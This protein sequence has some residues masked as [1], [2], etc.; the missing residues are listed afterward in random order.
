MRLGSHN[1]VD[2]G[3]FDGAT[4]FDWFRRRARALGAD[5][6]QAEVTGLDIAGGRVTGVRLAS[7]EAV[8]VGA[9]V[10]AAGPR[11]AEVARMAG[12]DLPVEPRR[13][14]TYV[15]EAAEPLP[16]DLPLTID[17]AGVHMRTDGRLYM[18]GCAPEADLAVDPTDFRD[19]PDRWQEHVWPVLAARVPGFERI[20]LRRSWVGHYAYNRLDQN[21]ILGP[22][23]E[24]PNLYFANGFSGHGLQQAP[25][26]GRGLAEL[27]VHGRY[28]SLDLSA[29]GHDRIAAGRPLVEPAII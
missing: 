5:F 22:A 9:V 29:L 6:V 24:I 10:N 2:E 20:K 28:L 25:A 23:A 11:A 4:M 26:V 12:L 17:P 3:Y 18:A 7:G 8:A 27:L 1:P 19:D 16:A 14:F 15:F 13:R 21:A